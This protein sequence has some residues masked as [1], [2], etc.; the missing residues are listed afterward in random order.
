MTRKAP[1]ASLPPQESLEVQSVDELRRWLNDHHRSAGRGCWLVS[2]KKAAGDR[3]VS[4]GD[5]VDEL[6]CYGW[7]DSKSGSVDANRTRVWIA[8]RKAG[9]GWSKINKA[10]VERLLRANRIAPAG[11]A[12]IAA[13]K[14]DGSWSRL[15][16]SHNGVVPDDL[17]AALALVPSARAQFDA[18]SASARR[19]ILEWIDQA[20]RPETRAKRVQETARLAA[21]GQR[22]N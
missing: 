3:Y 7:I 12:V 18:F 2:Y 1:L 4:Y 22:A 16:A 6:L 8:P 19:A 17:A 9:S 13:A 10:H 14:A 5:I 11:L 20:K 15:D 21:L